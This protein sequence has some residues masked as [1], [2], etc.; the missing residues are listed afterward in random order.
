[1][2]QILEHIRLIKDGIIYKYILYEEHIAGKRNLGRPE[3][4]YS[5]VCKLGMKQLNKRE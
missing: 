2:V 5:H 3:L 4:R 1:M